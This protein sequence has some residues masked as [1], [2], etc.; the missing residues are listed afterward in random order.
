[1]D[2][3][4]LDRRFL[5]RVDY[6]LKRQVD[7]ATHE[8]QSTTFELWHICSEPGGGEPQELQE[9]ARKQSLARESLVLAF[10]RSNDFVLNGTVPKDLEFLSETGKSVT[11]ASNCSRRT[12]APQLFD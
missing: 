8:H 6:I 3:R 12:A 9:S 7:T 5:D 2:T 10:K 1:M 11:K 4:I